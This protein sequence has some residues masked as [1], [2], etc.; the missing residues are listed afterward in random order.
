MGAIGIDL[1]P[2]TGV[3]IVIDLNNEPL[4][5]DDNSVDFIFSSHA[6]EHLTVEGFFHVMTEAYRVLKPNAQFKIVVPYFTSGLNFAYPFH[7]NNICFNE[8]TFRFFSS[9]NDCSAIEKEFFATPSCRQWGLRY[10]A[11]KE[12]NIEFRTLQINK[13]YFPKYAHLS[14]EEKE[15]ACASSLNV[16]D[17]ISYSLQAIKPCPARPECAPISPPDD[18][19]LFVENQ[20]SFLNDQIL[21]LASQGISSLP[22]IDRGKRYLNSAMVG[23][24]YLTDDILT[25][26]NFFIV[27]LDD[28]IQSLRRIIDSHLS[29]I[30][31]RS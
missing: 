30:K 16:A 13:F 22:E 6:L 19:Y 4:P 31:I 9:E 12:I 3:D 18:P 25:P 8:H 27:E 14:I 20:L 10:S 7:N 15:L 5:F 23:K 24:L 1:S 11:N 21:F 26:V 17:Q 2:L 29:R 28:S